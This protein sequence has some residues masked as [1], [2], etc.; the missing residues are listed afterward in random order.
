[1]FHPTEHT[2]GVACDHGFFADP[3]PRSAL[4]RRAELVLRVVM[5]WRRRSV[6]VGSPA[7]LPYRWMARLPLREPR[8]SP[9][10][11]PRRRRDP[12]RASPPRRARGQQRAASPRR[13]RG[14][15][16]DDRPDWRR[17]RRRARARVGGDA[18]EAGPTRGANQRPRTQVRITPAAAAPLTPRRAP[19]RGGTHD[20]AAAKRG[21]CSAL[22]APVPPP[23]RAARSPDRGLPP[24]STTA[25]D[26]TRSARGSSA[27]PIS[28]G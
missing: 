1:M 21:R 5:P 6:R 13:R 11:L 15:E 24:T 4:A 14:P 28:A 8:R 17:A 27:M 25:A 7:T 18:G 26:S 10:S 22:C 9:Q 20:R 16:A 2:L 19:G 3:P 23:P 12:Q